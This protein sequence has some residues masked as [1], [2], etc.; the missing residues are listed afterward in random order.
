MTLNCKE[1]AEKGASF[2]NISN[3]PL[4]FRPKKKKVYPYSCFFNNC[5]DFSFHFHFFSTALLFASPQGTPRKS[6]KPKTT[7]MD[8]SGC[9]NF[10]FLYFKQNIKWGV[11]CFYIL[12]KIPNDIC[13]NKVPMTLQ[14]EKQN[15]HVRGNKWCHHPEIREALFGFW[16]YPK[17]HKR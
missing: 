13:R 3:V 11:C 6:G 1:R 14:I 4:F 10:G 16:I 2:F 15:Q 8:L 17:S 12:N 9:A 5:S 7:D